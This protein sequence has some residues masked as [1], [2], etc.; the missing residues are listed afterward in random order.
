MQEEREGSGVQESL[1]RQTWFYNGLFLFLNA[2]YNQSSDVSV[3][4]RDLQ[5][6]SLLVILLSLPRV[7][8]PC[9]KVLGSSSRYCKADLDLLSHVP[10]SCTENRSGTV[11]I[12]SSSRSEGW[13]DGGERRGSDLWLILNSSSCSR[14]ER[15]FCSFSSSFLFLLFSSH[16]L[17]N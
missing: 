13:R 3:F 11:S 15:L 9:V 1:Y 2:T 14:C 16:M 7:R 8:P 12:W 10:L 17:L 5:E 6:Q 4:D